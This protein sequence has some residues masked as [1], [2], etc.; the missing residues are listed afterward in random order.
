MKFMEVVGLIGIV[1]FAGVVIAE[2]VYFTVEWDEA[3]G[4]ALAILLS[5]TPFLPRVIGREI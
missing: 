2:A 1:F 4:F 5:A 3:L